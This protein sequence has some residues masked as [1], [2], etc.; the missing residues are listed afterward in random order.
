MTH[1]PFKKLLAD[2]RAKEAE[3][4][5]RLPHQGVGV[6]FDRHEKEQIALR[7]QEE[8]KHRPVKRR[9]PAM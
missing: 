4:T 7:K 2:R 6:A 1:T 3:S 9:P 8:N 5:A